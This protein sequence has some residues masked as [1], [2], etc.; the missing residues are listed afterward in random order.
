MPLWLCADFVHLSSVMEQQ[1]VKRRKRRRRRRSENAKNEYI[2]WLS[3][4]YGLWRRVYQWMGLF[5][6][7]AVI[8]FVGL[9]QP[10]W[11]PFDDVLSWW[12][13]W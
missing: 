9:G 6:I 1:P 3:Y 10:I 8:L 5:L 2:A 13:H 7:L 12:G 4:F 11:T